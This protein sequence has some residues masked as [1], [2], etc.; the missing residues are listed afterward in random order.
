VSTVGNRRWLEGT[1]RGILKSVKQVRLIHESRFVSIMA[2]KHAAESIL[3][4]IHRVLSNVRTS[5]F[6]VDLVSSKPLEPSVLE[7]LG[8]TTNAVIR[9]DPSGKKVHGSLLSKLVMKTNFV[10][11]QGCGYLDPQERAR[12]EFRE[13]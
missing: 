7:E 8:R 11:F 3:Y 1:P 4:R 2:P 12:R 5:D 10:H 9:L 6:A 13:H